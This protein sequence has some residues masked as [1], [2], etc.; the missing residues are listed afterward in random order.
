[1]VMVTSVTSFG[2]SGLYD[3]VVQRFTAIVLLAYTLCVGSFVL[4]HPHLDYATW[5]GFFPLP[6]C[7]SSA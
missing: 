6:G 3:W 2:R 4:L 5:R 1:M 7:R